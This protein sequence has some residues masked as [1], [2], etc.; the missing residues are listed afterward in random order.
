MFLT[1]FSKYTRLATY[2]G[3]VQNG[4]NMISQNDNL[5]ITDNRVHDGDHNTPAVFY[6]MRALLKPKFKHGVIYQ[7][8]QSDMYI[9]YN[10]DQKTI[11]TEHEQYLEAWPIYQRKPY[12]HDYIMNERFNKV[13]TKGYR[14]CTITTWYIQTHNTYNLK[15]LGFTRDGLTGANGLFEHQDIDIIIPPA[16]AIER[17]IHFTWDFTDDQPSYDNVYILGNNG[18]NY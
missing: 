17:R 11:Y 10:D 8:I 7:R 2:G 14:N 9:Q 15:E 4:N 18:V 3:N 1:D 6:G 16:D 12:V 13:Y 5:S